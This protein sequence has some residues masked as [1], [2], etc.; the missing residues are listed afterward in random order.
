MEHSA[1]HALLLCG[2]TVACGGVLAFWWLLRPAARTS[3]A[4]IADPLIA[5]AQRLVMIGALAAAFATACDFFVQAAEIE[6]QTVFGGVDLALVWRFITVTTVGQL[7]STRG[8]LLLLAAAAI[9]FLP[10]LWKWSVTGLLA[11]G[12][13][14]ATAF[15]SHAAAQ[16]DGRAVYIICQ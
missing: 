11:F 16:P 9:R 12:A 10:G 14:V 8:I 15:V 2:L 5:S 13:L 4:A 1:L 3:P 7:D 6:N